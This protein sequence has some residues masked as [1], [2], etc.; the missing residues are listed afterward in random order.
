MLSVLL[1]RSKFFNSVSFLL[2]VILGYFRP[3]LG[4]FTVL[5]IVEYFL[6]KFCTDIFPYYSYRQNEGYFLRNQFHFVYFYYF[7]DVTYPYVKSINWFSQFEIYVEYMIYGMIYILRVITWKFFVFETSCFFQRLCVWLLT[8]IFIM[9]D[10]SYIGR[11][12]T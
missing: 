1:G 2:S 3:T 7:W 8:V 4:H 6:Q 5:R 9:Y 12:F 10:P 11:S